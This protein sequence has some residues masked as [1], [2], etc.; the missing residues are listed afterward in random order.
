MSF[1]F[2]FKQKTAYEIM[3]S[4]V[5]SEMCIRDSS[6]TLLQKKVF[7]FFGKMNCFL[8][9]YTLLSVLALC[10]ADKND[11]KSD[12]PVDIIIG[13]LIMVFGLLIFIS[14]N[15]ITTIVRRRRNKQLQAKQNNIPESKPISQP[16]PDKDQILQLSLIHI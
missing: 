10:F 1:F 15:E 7:F 4:L 11:S 2:F 3:P 6:S 12:K 13:V 9:L 8:R 16:S 14:A 5:G